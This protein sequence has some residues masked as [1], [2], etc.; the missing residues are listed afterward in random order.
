[1]VKWNGSGLKQ[2]THVSYSSFL[3]AAVTSSNPGL[4]TSASSLHFPA[5]LLWN[6]GK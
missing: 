3:Y 4:L 5:N 2:A 1:M 6:K